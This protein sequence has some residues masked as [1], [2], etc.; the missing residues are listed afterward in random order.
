VL[1][2]YA[3]KDNFAK[4]GIFNGGLDVGIDPMRLSV[5]FN[6][7]ENLT[8]RLKSPYPSTNS[9]LPPDTPLKDQEKFTNHLKETSSLLHGS[10]SNALP[11]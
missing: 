5:D 11:G 4:S 8:D 2:I 9:V 7:K 6:I 1:N 3:N 10:G